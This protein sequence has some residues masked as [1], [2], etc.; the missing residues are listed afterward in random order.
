[1]PPTGPTMRAEVLARLER[2]AR[3]ETEHVTGVT[4]V[5]HVTTR[6]F[7]SSPPVTCYGSGQAVTSHGVQERPVV[8]PVTGV[9]GVTRSKWEHVERAAIAVVDGGVPEA[10]VPAWAAFQVC[11]PGHL[12]ATEWYR[13]VDDAGRFLD[14]WAVLALE[15]GWEPPD[16]FGQGALAEFCAGETIRALRPDGAVTRTGRLFTRWAVRKPRQK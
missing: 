6:I 5:T 3:G 7:G 15:F 12:S 16:I 11:R 13:A 14:Q 1:M 4:P 10:F 8:T 9:T 2:I